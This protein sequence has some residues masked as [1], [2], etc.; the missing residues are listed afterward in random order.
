MDANL[1]AGIIKQYSKNAI[2]QLI[3]III[4]MDAE[5]FLNLRLPYHANVIKI[6]ETIK[7]KKGQNLIIEDIYITPLVLCFYGNA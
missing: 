7:S 3:R 4:G 2:P 1:L 5:L 6:F